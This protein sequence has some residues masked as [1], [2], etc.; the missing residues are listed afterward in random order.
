MGI[1]SLKIPGILTILQWMEAPSFRDASPDPDTLHGRM[2][3]RGGAGMV[4]G[5]AT[6]YRRGKA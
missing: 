4:L 6:Q 3:T 5:V 2:V 1:N